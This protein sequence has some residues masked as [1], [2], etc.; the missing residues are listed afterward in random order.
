MADNAALA[1]AIIAL[2][3]KRKRPP[4]DKTSPHQFTPP[5]H[6]LVNHAPGLDRGWHQGATM[7]RNPNF[8]VGW[9]TPLRRRA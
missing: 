9:F 2:I 6:D 1:A 5:P 7:R 8:P 3:A 4:D